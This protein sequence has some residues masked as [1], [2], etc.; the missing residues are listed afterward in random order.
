VYARGN[1]GPGQESQAAMFN[2]VDEGR[3]ALTAAAVRWKRDALPRWLPSVCGASIACLLG[4]SIALVP[5]VRGAHA[6]SSDVRADADWILS[7][8]LPDGSIANY[9][10]KNAIWPYL[11][12][13][14]TMGL[15]RAAEVTSDKKYSDAAWRWLAW[16][17]G[18]ENAQGFVTDYIVN[19]G[20]PASTGDMDSTDA[21]AGTFLLAARST[22]RVTADAV[23]LTSLKPGITGAVVAIEA[24][25]DVD[26]LTW[27]KPTWHVKYLMDQAETYAGL[28]AAVDLAKAL[29][30]SALAQRAQQDATK[31]KDGVDGL[32]NATANAYDWAKHDTGVRVPTNW[33]YLYSDA[34]QQAWAVAF[35]LVAA[36][37]ASALVTTFTT[38]QPAWASPLATALFSSGSKQ[39]VGYWPVAGW[40]LA[41]VSS[42]LV[43]VPVASIRS[44][45]LTT[46]R[47]WPFTTGNAG[48]LIAFESYSSATSPIAA[49]PQSLLKAVTGTVSGLASPA[50][51]TTIAASGTA[52]G[53]PAKTA[54]STTVAPATTTTRPASS[55]TSVTSTP[56]TTTVLHAALAGLS[57]N[58]ST[59]P[60]G[61]DASVGIGPLPTVHVSLTAGGSGG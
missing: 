49:L 12:N 58:L 48:Q 1:T 7:A 56:P 29:G 51:T 53:A 41:N 47:A 21:Y 9:V 17:Q 55:T 33:S 43:S 15:A 35:G 44:A 37:R 13:F 36:P 14:A 60:D 27:A 19:S 31:M 46:N 18:H 45:S 11:S 34:L 61:L 5:V 22:Y 42:S 24:T 4:A 3:R 59:R 28:L 26:G 2:R 23:R 20:V 54:V 38:T 6:S 8:Q 57:V 39:T 16:Y 25:Q 32:W 50:P 40:A 52:M 10:D 30:D